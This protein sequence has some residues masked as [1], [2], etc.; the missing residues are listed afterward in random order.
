MGVQVLCL[1]GVGEEELYQ[2]SV[3]YLAFI[4][5]P[6]TD[7][8]RVSAIIVE[9]ILIEYQLQ[10]L[11]VTLISNICINLPLRNFTLF[12]LSLS[13]CLKGVFKDPDVSLRGV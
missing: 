9:H 6:V 2:D 13:I 8:P 5:Y 7:I 12:L 3:P 11:S 1:N 10:F 4:S